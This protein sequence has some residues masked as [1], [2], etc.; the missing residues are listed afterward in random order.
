MITRLRIKLDKS[1]NYKRTDS[2]DHIITVEEIRDNIIKFS[3]DEP[4]IIRDIINNTLHT[5]PSVL[6]AS[7]YNDTISI[8]GL[9]DKGFM[10]INSIFKN[11]LLNKTL[12]IKNDIYKIVGIPTIENNVDFLPYNNGNTNVYTT[13]TPINIFNKHNH[14][15]FKSI[16]C[17]SFKDEK[18]DIT[19]TKAVESFYEDIKKYALEQIRNSIRYSVSILLNKDK[20]SFEFI[21][22]IDIEW[23]RIQV[24]FHHYQS[25]EKKMPMII[26]KFRSNFVLPRFIGYKVGKGFGEIILKD[27]YKMLK[28]E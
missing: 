25:E 4:E 19:N 6:Y 9:A 24:V 3:N 22:N 20:A 16:L 18:F 26:G 15:V 14:K 21:D 1:I 7:P 2:L 17:R 12:K 28:G 13:L 23:E 11:V 27:N 8:Y 10:A 5:L